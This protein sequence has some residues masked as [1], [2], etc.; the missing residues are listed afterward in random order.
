MTLVPASQSFNAALGQQASKVGMAE[1]GIIERALHLI[2]GHK[3]GD[4]VNAWIATVALMSHGNS[5][6]QTCLLWT[7]V[8][9]IGTCCENICDLWGVLLVG[10][11]NGKQEGTAGKNTESKFVNILGGAAVIACFLVCIFYI[12]NFP[13]GISS[14]TTRWSEFGGYLSGVLLPVISFLTLAAILR[15]IYLQREML[16][17]QDDTFKAQ[18]AQAERLSEEAAQTKID[19]RKSMILSVI[20]RVV[21][22]NIRDAE[23]LSKVRAES[24]QL[25]SKIED[26]NARV[27]AAFDISRLQERIQEVDKK[28]LALDEIFYIVS[29]TDYLSIELLQSDYE[30]RMSAIY[31]AA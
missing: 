14:S 16:K 24:L 8:Y 3:V 11:F 25:F 1:V 15:T 18:I 10:T 20:D 9:L 26:S 7:W 28:R 6:G 27:D 22:S 2:V 19:S 5:P 12:V 17:L 23:S 21:A 31:Q 29:M 13:S 30:Q 4:G